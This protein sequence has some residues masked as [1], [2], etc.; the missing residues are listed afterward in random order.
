MQHLNVG[1]YVAS[2]SNTSSAGNSSRPDAHK[3]VALL[4]FA[5]HA[6]EIITS[7]VALWLTQVGRNPRS[8]APRLCLLHAGPLFPVI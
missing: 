8:R 5:E 6:R 2:L 1:L 7:E 3:P 4:V